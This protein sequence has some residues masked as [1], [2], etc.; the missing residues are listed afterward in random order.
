MTDKTEIKGKCTE[1]LLAIQNFNNDINNMIKISEQISSWINNGINLTSCEEPLN[2]QIIT[3][4]NKMKSLFNEFKNNIIKLKL[5][6]DRIEN[7]NNLS[8]EI[9]N[10]TE[11]NLENWE[12]M[13]N[14]YN[15]IFSTLE[16]DISI[17][18]EASN[19]IQKYESLGIKLGDA[20]ITINEQIDNISNNIIISINDLDNIITQMQNESNKVEIENTEECEISIKSSHIEEYSGSKKAVDFDHSIIKNNLS[21]FEIYIKFKS[22]SYQG[23]PV[24]I[25]GGEGGNRIYLGWEVNGGGRMLIGLGGTHIL[26]NKYY[27]SLAGTIMN[28]K[29]IQYGDGTGR[30]IINDVEEDLIDIPEY[31][32]TSVNTF[33]YNGHYDSYPSH[34]GTMY[35]YILS[36]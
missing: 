36:A 8:D 23:N 15:N 25:G 18:N 27:S 2:T 4:Q 9:S 21:K 29:F 24:M 34:N 20:I 19:N 26:S 16:E 17:L 32:Y 6:D 35:E 3:A 1:L 11:N 13:I 12:K 22:N 31:N 10:I 14:I 33:Y 7:T 28:M 5:I 30:F